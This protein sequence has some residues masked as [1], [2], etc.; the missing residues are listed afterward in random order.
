[1]VTPPG[2]HVAQPPT[3][4]VPKIV[5][6]L[7]SSMIDPKTA[8]GL[9]GVMANCATQG[10]KSVYLALSTP[11]G[12]VVQGMTLYN[13]LK[14]MPFELTTHNV[15]NV[16][17]IG[18]AVFL[19]GSKRY[20]CKHSTF[21]FHGVGFDIKSQIRLEEKNIREMQTNILSNHERIGSVLEERTK[22]DKAIIPELF[23]EAQ[24]KDAAFAVGHGIIDEIRDFNVPPGSAVVSLVFQ[25]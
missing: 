7:F 24:T 25:S 8:Q 13:V 23:R 3:G 5:Y 19:A 16:D 10:V 4:A 12:D 1:M 14:G 22:I 9:L 2:I 20:A 17:S 21:M 6:V 11:G 15:G 18:N